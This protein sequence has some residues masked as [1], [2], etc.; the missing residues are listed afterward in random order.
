MPNSLKV[1]NVDYYI[2]YLSRKT[3]NCCLIYSEINFFNKVLLNIILMRYLVV[4][5]IFI[6][7]MITHYWDLHIVFAFSSFHSLLIS[8]TKY[9]FKII[10]QPNTVP[11]STFSEFSNFIHMFSKRISTLYI[12]DTEFLKKCS[13][14]SSFFLR[15]E[16]LYAFH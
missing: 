16:K 4:K 5:C 13:S 3:P 15:E 6:I 8:Y 14:S 2:I 9:I 1:W 12:F 10:R 11:Q 7:I